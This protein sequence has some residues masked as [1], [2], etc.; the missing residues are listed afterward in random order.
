MVFNGRP[1]AFLKPLLFFFSIFFLFSAQTCRQAQAQLGDSDF[2]ALI[3]LDYAGLEAVRLAVKKGNFKKAKK[4]Y[5]QFLRNRIYRYPGATGLPAGYP[6][7][8]RET[9]Q[10]LAEQVL[11]NTFTHENYT[12]HFDGQID[13][14]F[15]PTDNRQNPAYSGE[16][17]REWTVDF[18][19]HN[20]FKYL[21]DAFQ[22]TGNPVYVSKI[23]QLISHWIQQAPPEVPYRDDRWTSSWRTLEAG[24]RTGDAWPQAWVRIIQCNELKDAT[25]FEWAKSW[26]EH[27][28]YLEQHHGGLN[29]LTSEAKGLYTT[30]ILFPEFSQFGNWRKQALSRLERQL[31]T[32]FYPDGAH[33]ELSP[34]YHR[35]AAAAFA[36]VYHL[37]LLNGDEISPD[38]KAG[39]EKMFDYLLKI[40]LPDRTL[41]LL[42]DAADE[43]IVEILKEWA[44]PAFPGRKDYLWIETAGQDG[45]PPAK[46]SVLAPWAGQ[47]VMRNSWGT[48]ANYLLFEY[49]PFG[50]GAHQHEDKLGLHIAALGDLFVF[51]TGT[52][53]YGNSP[54][55]DYCLSTAAHS[56]MTIDGLGQNRK[57]EE[58]KLS[59]GREK[60][61]VNW[62]LNAVFDYAAA[63]YGENPHERYGAGSANLGTWR[64]HVLF[65]KPDLF[66]VADILL[67]ADEKPHTYVSHFHLNATTAGLDA[68]THTLTIREKGRPSFSITPLLVQ[69]LQ[70]E[71][72]EG[73]TTPEIL[74][75]ELSMER[76]DQP[77]PVLR[78]RQTAA[79]PVIFA[80]VFKASPQGHAAPSFTI[81]QVESPPGTA[82][83]VVEEEGTQQI[84]QITLPVSAEEFR[85][86]EVERAGWLKNS[87][88][89]VYD[90]G[91][92][93]LLPG[94]G[95]D[96]NY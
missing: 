59:L 66:F 88:G 2:F 23:D 62:T 83:I 12:Y 75:W 47:A 68:A 19:R 87:S 65:L 20:A 34:H 52:E 45:T 89:Q 28:T 63:S 6:S 56:A 95:S 35:I 4:A 86:K 32:D 38:L 30:G 44:I 36:E 22:E 8:K 40:S 73:Q 33:V 92:G 18:N 51:E 74:G 71:I 49:G 14:H 39:V 57:Q 69:G 80:Y 60:Y 58:E 26:M 72:I 13:W 82:A 21:A 16:Y 3:N 1:V 90:L 24:L 25:V 81:R 76:D 17:L 46:T 93:G 96:G 10:N 43:N 70:A 37:T 54:M 48:N 41:P 61:E 42:N 11:E 85:H 31:K 79:G 91:T 9:G 84:V 15:N 5:V 55:R 50:S 27:G 77:I 7:K 53:N 67:P 78:Y 64:R 29:W 94:S